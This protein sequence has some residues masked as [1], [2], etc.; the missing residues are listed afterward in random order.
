MVVSQ[1]VGDS[2]AAHA[3]PWVPPRIGVRGDDGGTTSWE[4]A[5]WVSGECGCG[6]AG[7]SFASLMGDIERCVGLA[8]SG[9]P[10][11]PAIWPTTYVGVPLV[12]TRR[13][14][15]AARLPPPTCDTT[16]ILATRRA[17]LRSGTHGR[18]RDGR[19]Y[20]HL[21]ATQPHPHT[22]Q[23]PRRGRS[24]TALVG[25]TATSTPTS[26]PLPTSPIPPNR[27][28]R[29]PYPVFPDSDRGP[30]GDAATP[31]NLPHTSPPVHQPPP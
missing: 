3:P 1:V 24:R 20:P 14:G 7:R 31:T 8:V 5:G 4:N 28:P 15:W 13:G 16:G 2:R 27:L 25:C 21:P 26:H 18:A 30:R 6:M 12:G 29:P 23:P 11:Q 19:G 17:G 9:Y 10:H 22:G